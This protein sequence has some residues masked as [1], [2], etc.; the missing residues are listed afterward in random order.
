MFCEEGFRF[1]NASDEC[2]GNEGR[3][4]LLFSVL[5]YY[6]FQKKNIGTMTLWRGPIIM[7]CATNRRAK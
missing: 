6:N 4:S 3:V 2:H 7:Q 1:T 5:Q